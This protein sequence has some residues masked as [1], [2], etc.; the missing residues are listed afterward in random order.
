MMWEVR[1]GHV[2]D[3][4]RAMPDAAVHCCV[5][6][7]PYFGLRSYKTEPQVWGGEVGHEHEWGDIGNNHERRYRNN[8]DGG[9]HEG[10]ATDK[11]LTITLGVQSGASCSCGAWRGELGLEPTPELYVQHIVEVFR[12]VRRTLRQDGT[13]FLNMGDSYYGGKGQ[14]AHGGSEKQRARFERNQSLNREY[15]EIGRPGWTA[16]LDRPHPVLKPKDLVGIPW[17]VAFALQAD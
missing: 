6:S 16:P 17:R 1:Q 5:T 15:Q 10:R 14:S 12:E 2:L 8:A 13:L 11:L 4:L 9:L 3:L 7:P